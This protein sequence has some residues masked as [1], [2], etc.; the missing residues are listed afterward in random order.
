MA[1][2]QSNQCSLPPC[3]PGNLLGTSACCQNVL[4]VRVGRGLHQL[5]ALMLRFDSEAELET[6]DLGRSLLLMLRSDGAGLEMRPQRMH[7]NRPQNP[8]EDIRGRL[9]AVDLAFRGLQAQVQLAVDFICESSDAGMHT[10]PL[11]VA[12]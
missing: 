3:T 11:A 5:V 2:P 7:F 9:A 8:F 6:H 4:Q 10:K 1:P 12:V